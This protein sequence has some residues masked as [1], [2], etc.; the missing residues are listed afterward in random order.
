MAADGQWAVDCQL[1][2]DDAGPAT[3]APRFL[4]GLGV[5]ARLHAAVQHAASAPASRTRRRR[6]GAAARRR[7]PRHAAACGGIGPRA[8]RLERRAA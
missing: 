2:G 1:A 8:P 3:A 7:Q 6:G 4:P 5:A